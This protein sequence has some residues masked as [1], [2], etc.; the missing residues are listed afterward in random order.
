MKYEAVLFDMD[1][2]V[3][4]TLTDLYNAVNYTL[5]QFDLPEVSVEKVR[6]SLGSGAAKL[7]QR[8]T[9]E[10]ID[11][12]RLEEVLSV[13]KPYYAA[14]SHMATK[15]YEGIIPLMERLKAMGVKQAIISNKPDDAVKDLAN[16]FFPGLLEQAVGESETVKRKPDPTAVLAAAGLLGVEPENAST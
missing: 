13:Y 11:P 7:I 2:T 16:I 15:P 10:G 6:A 3:L 12:V 14:N 5:R 9:P 4:N 1:G 8:C